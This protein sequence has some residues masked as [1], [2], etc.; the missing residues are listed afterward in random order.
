VNI[1]VAGNPE[2]VF[3]LGRS[4]NKIVAWF[5]SG[6]ITRRLTRVSNPST[7]LDY[8][9]YQTVI[10]RPF[11]ALNLTLFVQLPA[12]HPLIR[13]VGAVSLDRYTRLSG[14]FRLLAYVLQT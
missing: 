2:N 4:G 6:C 7:E 10:S 3:S 1:P 14:A 11:P 12:I 13:C 5:V 8:Q 9:R